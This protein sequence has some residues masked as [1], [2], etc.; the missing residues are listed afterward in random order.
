MM[1]ELIKTYSVKLDKVFES[2]PDIDAS[3]CFDFCTLALDYSEDEHAEN[4][5][6]L[7]ALKFYEKGKSLLQKEGVNKIIEMSEAADKLKD[8]YI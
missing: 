1:I 2:I 4:D 7:F 5:T 3:D 8:I 6:Y